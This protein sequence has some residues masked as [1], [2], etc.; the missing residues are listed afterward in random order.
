M[1]T[2]PTASQIVEPPTSGLQ[3]AKHKIGLTLTTSA[4]CRAHSTPSEVSKI[5]T[6]ILT[7]LGLLTVLSLS[8]RPGVGLLLA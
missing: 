7:I 3:L 5:P 6:A 8:G 4:P 1:L 2:S